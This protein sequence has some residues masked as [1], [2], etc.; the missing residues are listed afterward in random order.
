MIYVN[1]GKEDLNAKDNAVT[2]FNSDEAI[3]YFCYFVPIDHSL[4]DLLDGVLI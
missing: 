4:G 1:E 3:E 2:F